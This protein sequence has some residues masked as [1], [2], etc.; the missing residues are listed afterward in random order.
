MAHFMKASSGASGGLTRHYERHKK[1]RERIEKEQKN[2]QKEQE[3]I[4]DENKVNGASE[5]IV[6]ASEVTKS[7]SESEYIKFGNQDIDTSRTH[8]NYN[9]AEHQKMP[10]LE[11]IKQ[12]TS[13]VHCLNR[14]DV[15]IMC[16]WVVTLPKEITHLG[17]QDVFFEETYKFLEERYGKENVISAYVHLDESQPHMHFAFVPVVEDKQKGYLKVSAKERV[18]RVDLQTFH[19]DLSK[20]LENVFGRDVG[21][22]N[23]ATKDKNKSVEELKAE[24][25]EKIQELKAEAK[26]QIVQF[27]NKAKAEILATVD[28]RKQQYDAEFKKFDK[29]LE[30][31]ETQV[32]SEI[33]KLDKELQDKK[34]E[35]AEKIAE[36]SR[37]ILD[38]QKDTGEIFKTLDEIKALT[39]KKSF[40]GAITG[41]ELADIE[42]L[43][44]TTK[45][46]VG[47][48]IW[49]KKTIVE[50]KSVQAEKNDLEI[51]IPKIQER[52]ENAEMK[53]LEL[54]IENK[55]IQGQYDQQRLRF[56][57]LDND[58]KALETEV[59]EV[60][61]LMN[62][63]RNAFKQLPEDW[64][65]QL[66]TELID[67][68][69]EELESL[70][71]AMDNPYRNVKSLDDYK[72]LLNPSKSTSKS[73][74]WDFER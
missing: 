36:K 54:Q 58:F 33:F 2:A 30:N 6:K 69:E 40:T 46:F 3:R 53:V 62:D 24:T 1:D 21:V 51:K 29:I 49:L 61:A 57:K 25:K 34:S 12:R 8:L 65:D 66:G 48:E 55:G 74:D 71:V 14:K 5:K 70:A 67:E 23:Q 72:E 28:E 26:E 59:H 19:K 44:E 52:M 38:F 39:P 7:A 13:E 31:K 32:K 68:Y 63:Y 43:I 50:L 11:F 42:K 17:E 15:N 20:T 45:R 27:E 16:S 56:K 64:Q 73:L 60:K 18:N 41:V 10:Q 37:E 35:V 47:A 4:L 9:L 22:L